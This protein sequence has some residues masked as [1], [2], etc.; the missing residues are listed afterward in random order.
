VVA[1]NLNCFVGG[2]ERQPKTVL[3]STNSQALFVNLIDLERVAMRLI[4]LFILHSGVEEI[5]N[6]ERNL[7]HAIGQLK[8]LECTFAMM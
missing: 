4:L 7:S 8:A 5:L 6:S 2:V 1:L 3:T